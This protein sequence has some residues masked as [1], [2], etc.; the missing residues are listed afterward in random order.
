MEELNALVK[1]VFSSEKGLTITADARLPE[2]AGSPGT[3]DVAKALQ[4]MAM[5]MTFLK[6]VSTRFPCIVKETIR[7]V[8]NNVFNMQFVFK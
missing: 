6:Y 5:E 7:E 2:K 4:D 1:K 3:I 8:L